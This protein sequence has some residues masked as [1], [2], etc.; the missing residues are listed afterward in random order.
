LWSVN[1]FRNGVLQDGSTGTARLSYRFA[2]SAAEAAGFTDPPA[3]RH[4]WLRLA[5]TWSI[6]EHLGVRV[7]LPDPT[8]SPVSDGGGGVVSPRFVH[9]LPTRKS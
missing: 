8:Q 2:A 4:H 1:Y 6:A 3:A 5:E 7:V 9:Y